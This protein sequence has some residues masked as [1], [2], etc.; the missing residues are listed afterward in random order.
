MNFSPPIANLGPA[1]QFPGVPADGTGGLLSQSGKPAFKKLLEQASN[2]PGHAAR[3]SEQPLSGKEQINTGEVTDPELKE[4]LA[5]IQGLVSSIK[6]PEFV[7]GAKDL[8]PYHDLMSKLSDLLQADGEAET[9]PDLLALLSMIPEIQQVLTAGKGQLCLGAVGGGV[10]GKRGVLE[11]ISTILLDRMATGDG[12]HSDLRNTWQELR[13]ILISKQNQALPYKHNPESELNHSTK[14]HSSKNH[15]LAGL[16]P[17]SALQNHA[18]FMSAATAETGKPDVINKLDPR[19]KKQNGQS[20]SD[21]LGKN[22]AQGKAPRGSVQ[23]EAAGKHARTVAGTDGNM[24][25]ANLRARNGSTLQPP[26]AV[27]EQLTTKSPRNFATVMAGD[28]TLNATA[29]GVTR[30]GGKNAHENIITKSTN[31]SDEFQGMAENKEQMNKSPFTFEKGELSSI[32]RPVHFSGSEIYAQGT[33][34]ISQSAVKDNPVIERVHEN[35]NLR[36][37]VISQLKQTVLG[38]MNLNRNRAVLHLHPPELGSVRVEITV[39]QQSEIHANFIATTHEAKHLI[40][41]GMGDL[42]E[43]F[44]N[45]GFHLGSCNV[46]VSGHGAEHQAKENW[47]NPDVQQSWNRAATATQ[48]EA[49]PQAPRHIPELRRGAGVHIVV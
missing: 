45:N 23:E 17:E 11:D 10:Q 26:S 41:A 24:D 5:K 14:N 39:H 22:G 47:E 32:G 28:K 33:F 1:E 35:T 16:K 27:A 34:N 29:K 46:D 43:Q 7:A 36:V 44:S 18:S 13:N 37:E 30:K 3:S 6:N 15:K 4:A 9:N 48:D 12:D 21:T 38:A 25:N 40:Q 19:I 42:R 8:F 49:L 2:M 20:I 31:N